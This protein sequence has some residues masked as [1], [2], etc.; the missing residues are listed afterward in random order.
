MAPRD[1]NMGS[2]REPLGLLGC[3]KRPGS[4]FSQSPWQTE[5]E[6]GHEQDAGKKRLPSLPNAWLFSFLGKQA[7]RWTDSTLPLCHVPRSIMVNSMEGLGYKASLES[8]AHP[9]LTAGDN[10]LLPER[11]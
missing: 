8:L 11:F 3:L 4:R 1:L 9:P 2:L 10:I 5:W 6:L 7:G